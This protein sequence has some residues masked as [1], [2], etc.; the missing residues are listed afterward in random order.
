MI[1]KRVAFLAIGLACFSVVMAQEAPAPGAADINNVPQQV[2]QVAAQNGGSPKPPATP[3]T[4]PQK[5]AKTGGN[6]PPRQGALTTTE[7][8][9]KEA[10]ADMTESLMPLTPEHIHQLHELFDGIQRATSS[11]AGA[12]PKPTSSSVI[13]NLLPGA[14]PP[15][16]R[17]SAG[18]IT[19]LIF[20]DAT[21]APWPIQAYD[22]GN[23]TAFNIQWDKKGNTLL[24]QSVTAYNHGNLAVMLRGL[25]TPV[26]MTLVPGQHAVD[27]R[28]DMQVPRVGPNGHPTIDQLPAKADPELLNVLNGIPPAGARTLTVG[29]GPGSA[30]LS[31]GKMFLRTPLTVISPSWVSKMSASDE[32]VY[33]YLLP[34][35]PVVLALQ[36]GR[37]VSLKIKGF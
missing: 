15:V 20:L 13:V 21:G 33:A 34:Q 31:H 3:D 2:Q 4:Q 16:V 1:A 14:T 24:I 12:P 10:F 9:R 19:S 6:Q 30:W 7:D 35:A 5:A 17:L 8:L 23:P 32:M 29:G 28:I 26:M 25:N 36:H 22:V 11:S 27:Y 37:M 18:F